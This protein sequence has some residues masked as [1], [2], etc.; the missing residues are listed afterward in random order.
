M[1]NVLLVEDE[2]MV[3]QG[4]K[5]TIPWDEMGCAIV[6][7][8]D[9]GISA[10]ELLDT[11]SPDIILSDIRMPAMDGLQFAETALRHK[12]NVRI[13][14]LT[15]F[16]DFKYAQQA[17]KLGAADF[18]LK[19]TNPDELMNVFHRLTEQLDQERKAKA[20]AEQLEFKVGAGQP[21]IMEKLLYDILLDYAGTYEKELFH[22][23]SGKQDELEAFRVVLLHMDPAPSPQGDDDHRGSS[24]RLTSRFVQGSP[25]PL[26]RIG[27]YR[28]AIVLS[29]ALERGQADDGVMIA[30]REL[31]FHASQRIAVGISGVHGGI[32]QLKTAY[33]EADHAL[34]RSVLLGG[35]IVYWGVEAGSVEASNEV[36]EV[37]PGDSINETLRFVELIKWGVPE[38]IAQEARALHSVMLHRCKGDPLKTR[39]AFF[40]FMLS[41]YSALLQD[42][43]AGGA[44][45]EADWLES[46]LY[47]S[48]DEA[49]L[50]AYIRILNE[51]NRL[52]GQLAATATENEF[53]RIKQFI[54]EHACE[55]ISLQR[56]AAHY[57]MSESY[58]SRLFKREVGTS[59]MDY[60]TSLRVERAKEQLANPRLR[61]YEVSLQVGYEDARYFSQIF[62]KYTGETPTEFR[63]RLG[64]VTQSL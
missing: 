5:E 63:K 52:C 53:E 6:G 35:G 9:N 64:I 29:G 27:E 41:L 56:I 17:I 33:V 13:V 55:H 43:E 10:L 61:I 59:F 37:L 8:A 24:R 36:P 23:F 19:P 30:L 58:F 40:R 54:H 42:N 34:F 39:E 12:P 47:V 25:F 15:G 32:D 28:F 4:L 11:L 3:R 31:Q 48:H 1:Y 49:W 57:N 50:E 62:R 44:I 38:T 20:E 21:L 18:L 16:D 60:L 45:G 26:V 2:Y 51:W 14:F 7:E 22:E 46:S